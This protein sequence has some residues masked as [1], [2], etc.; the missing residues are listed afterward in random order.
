MLAV[1]EE[2]L[3][4]VKEIIMALGYPHFAFLFLTLFV[5]MFRGQIG[6]LISRMT[7][8]EK[9]GVRA[10][11]APEAQREK[12]RAEAVQELLLAVGDSI[13]LRDIEGRIRYDLE[14]RELETET[15]SAKVLIKH[16][17]GMTI[18]LEFE[19]VHNLIFG[20]QIR[21]LRRLNEVVG[22]G[23]TSEDIAAYFDHVKELFE[24]QLGGWSLDEYMGF[25]VGRSLVIV[26]ENTYHVTNLG[27]EYLTWMARNGRSENRPL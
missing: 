22:Q 5:I 10:M 1:R 8:I 13:V 17:A 21:L 11:P 9:S 4:M 12:Q 20:S 25:L 3:S 19:Q 26:N 27:V 16:L 7:S 14:E 15:D 6:A 18:L 2:I 24:E 23:Q